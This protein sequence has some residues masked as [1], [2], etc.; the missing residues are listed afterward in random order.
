MVH[1]KPVFS[2]PVR[3][4]MASSTE[5]ARENGESLFHTMVRINASQST[6]LLI[7]ILRHH[8][9]QPYRGAGTSDLLGL[10]GL[11]LFARQHKPEVQ[12]ASAPVAYPT[13]HVMRKHR[14]EV[15][16]EKTDRKVRRAHQAALGL[17]KYCIRYRAGFPSR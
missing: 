11:G 7:E 17:G 3:T 4:G 12:F 14:S 16:K 8:W 6:A 2:V 15:E 13:V 1:A 10:V 9:N 5:A